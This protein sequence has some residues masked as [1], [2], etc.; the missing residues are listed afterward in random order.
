[1]RKLGFRHLVLFLLNQVKGSLQR[2]LDEFT[3]HALGLGLGNSLSAAAVCVARRALSFTVFTALNR[4]FIDLIA[5][6]PLRTGW[7]GHRVLAVDG[8]ILNLPATPELYKHFGG[9]R[10]G[11]H[12]LPMARLSQ[13]FDV[14]SG[15]T[16]HAELGPLARP[17]RALAAGHIE[18]APAD[19]ILVYDRG[20]PGF[21][22]M[23]QHRQQDRDFCMRVARGFN[24]DADAL[25]KSAKAQ[26]QITIEP[27]PK[28]RRE[29]ARQG[30]DSQPLTLRLVRVKL[31][32]GEVEI[33]IT[34]L[35]DSRYPEADFKALYTMRWS[36]ENDYRIQK[37]RLQIENFSGRRAHVIAQDVHAKIL[38]KNL[39][40]WLTAQAQSRLDEAAVSPK[41]A[42]PKA[43]PATADDQPKRKRRQRI[44]LTDALHVCK[45]ALINALL[46][47][48]STI[49]HILDRLARYR[50]SERKNRSF[51]RKHR[52][53][54]DA[55]RFPSAYK[56]TA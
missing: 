34:S 16:W 41:A 48:K 42:P 56:Q 31:P 24:K 6:R 43:K 18:H 23:A 22:L 21:L 4:R 11:A 39:A 33:L 37:S 3:E 44:N 26:R 29:C 54:R 36:V 19:S 25:M 1:M 45:H 35:L 50:H 27:N 51:P 17:E 7:H 28:V 49:D 47:I 38:T 10:Q 15:L 32:T 14:D 12:K 55:I 20:Y 53:G 9:Q 13:L 30:V 40:C 2:E 46:G 5:Q 8:S 52:K